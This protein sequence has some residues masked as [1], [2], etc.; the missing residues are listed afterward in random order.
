[1]YL[2]ERSTRSSCSRSCESFHP[3]T[4]VF[5]VL[6]VYVAYRTFRDTAAKADPS[7][8]AALRPLRRLVPAAAGF[9]G[10][11]LFVREDG[12]LHPL[13]EATR[14]PPRC[15]PELVSSER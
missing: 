5:G 13:G 11:R 7:A 4:Y 6:L 14:R 12:S 10:R 15:P 9:R 2:I 3:V 8:G 1:V